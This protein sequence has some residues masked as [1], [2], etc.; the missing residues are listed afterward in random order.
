MRIYYLEDQLSD[1]DV[2]FVRVALGFAG[3]CS[4]VRIPH[5]LPAQPK[6][7]TEQVFRRHQRLLRTALRHAGIADDRGT[8][9]VLVAPSKM[10]W[11]SVLL[12]AVYSETGAFPWLV[13]TRE[14]REAIG[15]PGETRILDAQGL[16]QA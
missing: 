5:V 15:N 14:Q 10:Y 8:Q 13:Q 6:T 7:L 12:N 2:A 16:M 3:V 11:Y 1:D 9:V 4:Q